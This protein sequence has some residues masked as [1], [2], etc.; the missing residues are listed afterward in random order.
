MHPLQV[1]I[2]ALHKASCDLHDATKDMNFTDD[3]KDHL[4][5]LLVGYLPVVMDAAS[6]LAKAA[7]A[8]F[9]E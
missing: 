6:A 3:E 9:T 7:I 5:E 1:A 4:V 2:G 8:Y